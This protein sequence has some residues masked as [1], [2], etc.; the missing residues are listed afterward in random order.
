MIAIA[1]MDAEV[2]LNRMDLEFMRRHHLWGS[3]VL[4]LKRIHEGELETAFIA[5]ADNIIETSTGTYRYS[6]YEEL[7]EKGWRVD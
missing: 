6:S 3:E 2:L 7:F 1:Y 4:F 5:K